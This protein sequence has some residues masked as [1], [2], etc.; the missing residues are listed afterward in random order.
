MDKIN[1][2]CIGDSHTAGFPLFDPLYGGDPLSSYEYWFDIHL[3]NHFSNNLFDIHNKGICGQF[4]SEV[5]HR[6]KPTLSK[7][8][9]DLVIFWAGANDIAMGYSV[10]RI[11]ENLWQA[12]KFSVSKSKAFMLVTI[13]PMNWSEIDTKI[14]QLNEKIRKNSNSDTYLY[15][16]AYT[17]LILKRKGVLNPIYDAGDGVHLSIDGYE[18]VGKEIF[19]QAV[20]L[21]QVILAR[22]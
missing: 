2:L 11:W 5:V 4:S 1:I 15:A 16:D 12:Y 3:S 17:A 7:F 21:I 8:S 19:T 22:R 13:P 9:Y 18:Q 10:K 20:P 14:V 6:L